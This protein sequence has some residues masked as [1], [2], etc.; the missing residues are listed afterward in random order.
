MAKAKS[1]F[2]RFRK[3]FNQNQTKFIILG[4]VFFI[5]SFL[6]TLPYFNIILNKTLTLFIVWILAVFLLNL[7]GKVSVAGALV[8]LGLCPL[9][10]IFK[11]EPV[12]EELANLAFGLLVIG[13]GQEFIRESGKWKR[14]KTESRKWTT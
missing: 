13:V 12:A 6:S 8:C 7:S 10:L 5:S 14:G 4:I 9:F 2:S 11:K 3:F 1:T